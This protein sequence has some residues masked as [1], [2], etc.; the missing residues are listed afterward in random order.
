MEGIITVLMK[1]S[2]LEFDVQD[3][4]DTLKAIEGVKNSHDIR[5]EFKYWEKFRRVVILPL[6]NH[7]KLLLKPRT[8][9]K[10]D[11]KLP[12]QLSR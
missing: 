5:M 3:L 8:L 2:P 6:V 1:G 4:H 12:I 11:I 7:K 10:K 9:L